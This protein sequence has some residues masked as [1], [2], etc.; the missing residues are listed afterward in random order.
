MY[1]K[2]SDF[3]RCTIDVGYFLF[4]LNALYELS[5]N[6]VSFIY[7]IINRNNT[8]YTYF[9][10]E[11]KISSSISRKVEKWGKTGISK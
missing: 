9:T 7:E 6:A 8:Y 2:N 4:C 10:N 3:G 5:N 1:A 11:K